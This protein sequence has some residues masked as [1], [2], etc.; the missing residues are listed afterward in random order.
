M[1]KA[2]LELYIDSEDRKQALCGHV[3]MICFASIYATERCAWKK[4]AR[5]E[6]LLHIRPWQWRYSRL[7]RT[8]TQIAIQTVD[9]ATVRSA[10]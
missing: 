9:T 10:G 8:E 2:D 4:A 7:S 1:Q 3:S 6:E 5:A